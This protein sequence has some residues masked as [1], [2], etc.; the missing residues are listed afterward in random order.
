M[1]YQSEDDKSM[2]MFVFLPDVK[3]KDSVAYMLRKMSAETI[4]K[5]VNGTKN[6]HNVKV[7]F[8]KVNINKEYY[9]LKKVSYSQCYR[10]LKLLN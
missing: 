4:R 8:P 7:Q 10:V 1:P 2:S 5:A 3:S 6:Y 9:H